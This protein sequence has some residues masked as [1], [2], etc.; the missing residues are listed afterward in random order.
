MIGKLTQTNLIAIQLH[1][2]FILQVCEF[3]FRPNEVVRTLSA[4]NGENGEDIVVNLVRPRLF[5]GA[6]PSQM[7]NCPRYLSGPQYRRNALH[8]RV[9]QNHKYFKRKKFQIEEKKAEESR[10]KFKLDSLQEIKDKLPLIDTNTFWNIIHRN[11]PSS[12]VFIN[13]VADPVPKVKLSV[14][15][16]HDMKVSVYDDTVELNIV[17]KVYKSNKISNILELNKVLNYVKSECSSLCS[18]D[19]ENDTAKIKLQRAQTILSTIDLDSCEFTSNTIE[20]I[21]EQLSLL[22]T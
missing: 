2:V 15:I 7:P 19:N 5:A 10:L 1:V 20:F 13:L 4:E 21:T 16:S 8:L 6:V 18:K 3:H 11:D 22:L 9:K 12:I 14:C 17:L